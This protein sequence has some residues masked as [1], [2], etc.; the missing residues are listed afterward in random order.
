MQCALWKSCWRFVPALDAI[1]SAALGLCAA[2]PFLG[3]AKQVWASQNTILLH[4]RYLAHQQDSSS[5]LP[6]LC[7]HVRSPGEVDNFHASVIEIVG[8]AGKEYTLNCLSPKH[9]R[10]CDTCRPR[11]RSCGRKWPWQS[12]ARLPAWRRRCAPQL[13]LIH[14]S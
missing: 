3:Q 6:C 2:N 10:R 9:G 12:A 11:M 4:L 5:H 14:P 8:R 13:L 1:A 7:K